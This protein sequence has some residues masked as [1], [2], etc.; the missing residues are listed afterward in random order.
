MTVNNIAKIALLIAKVENIWVIH[1]RDV[2]AVKPNL[3]TIQFMFK[4]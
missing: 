4:F 1:S 3:L 2:Q